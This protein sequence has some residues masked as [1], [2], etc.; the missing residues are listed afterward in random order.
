MLTEISSSERPS[1]LEGLPQRPPQGQ[2]HGVGEPGGDATARLNFYQH[3]VAF[4]Q[5][6]CANDDPANGE[7]TSLPSTGVAGHGNSSRYATLK[8]FP[9]DNDEYPIVR[10]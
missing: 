9:D 5:V 2:Q 3:T 4:S 1:P 6:C 10:S 8:H 7:T